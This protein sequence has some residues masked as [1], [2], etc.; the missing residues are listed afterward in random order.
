MADRSYALVLASGSRA[1]IR[2]ELQTGYYLIGRHGE[3]QIRPKSRSVSRRHCLLHVQPDY[4]AV[5][6]LRSTSG[7]RLGAERLP[8]AVWVEVS[9]G[10]Q[11]RCGKIA[12]DVVAEA[13]V[14]SAEPPMLRGEAWQE[15]DI[16]GFLQAAD[17]DDREV[18]Y[19]T[20]RAGDARRQLEQ[21]APEPE[22]EP[23]VTIADPPAAKF[24]TAGVGR[25]SDAAARPRTFG[26]S[27]PS[28]AAKKF[29]WQRLRIVAAAALVAVTVGVVVWQTVRFVRGPEPRIVRG[30]D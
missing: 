15:I 10:D 20:I 21:D 23:D 13:P 22:V 9:P 25:E 27:R 29:D 19:E 28:G 16:A 30:I 26:K 1:G 4:L 8:P 7:T 12:F 18:R 24:P 11:L 6:D 2:A 14:A 3:C 17:D 5:L